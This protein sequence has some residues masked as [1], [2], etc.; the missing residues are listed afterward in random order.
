M[1]LFKGSGDVGS[2]RCFVQSISIRLG[3]SVQGLFTVV[4]SFILSF[5]LSLSKGRPFMVR[6]AHHER[7]TPVTLENEKALRVGS[8][9][10]LG[11]QGKCKTPLEVVS[12]LP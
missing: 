11:E 2:R 5:A 10:L 12:S 6:Q 9:Y 7:T 8:P 1:T 4:S 3:E